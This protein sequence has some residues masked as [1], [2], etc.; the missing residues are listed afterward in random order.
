[1]IDRVQVILIFLATRFIS[2]LSL[3]ASWPAYLLYSIKKSHLLL[4]R[5]K[6]ALLIPSVFFVPIFVA[7][8]LPREHLTDHGGCET[9]ERFLIAGLLPFFPAFA[10][11]SGF[12][13][14]GRPIF[15]DF[16]SFC[17]DFKLVKAAI[18][19]GAIPPIVAVIAPASMP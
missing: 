19:I 12:G 5:L 11:A 8:H 6:I 15:T 7:S 17:L 10:G 18:T 2:S 4:S 14:G 16:Y 13:L 1:M 9:R 3:G